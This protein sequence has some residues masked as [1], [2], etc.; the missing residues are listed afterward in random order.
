MKAAVLRIG[1]SRAALASFAGAVALCAGAAGAQGPVAPGGVQSLDRI[2]AVVGSRPILL[3]EAI[4]SVNAMRAQG[5]QMP[6]DSLGQYNLLLRVINDLVDNEVV[7]HVANNYKAA[8]TDEDVARQVDDQFNESRKR[9]AS[10]AEFRDA[11]RRDGFGTPEDYR[12]TIRESAKRYKLQQHGF[13]SLKAHGR[14]S[15]PVHVTEAEVN[16][17]FEASRERLP[18]RPATV[19]FRQ[20]VIAPRASPAAMAVARAKAESLV[21]LL[22]GGAD[23]ATVAKRE[24]MDPVSRE[25]GGDLGWAR[26]GSGFVPEFERAIF[27]LP[28]GQ[29]SNAVETSFGFHIIRVD[30]VQPAE[31]KSRHIL[32]APTLDSADVTRARLVADSVLQRWSGGASYDSLAARYHDPAEERSLLDGFPVDSLPETYRTAIEGVGLREFAK[33]FEIPDPR[34]NHPKIGI[35]QVLERREGGDYTVADWKERIRSQLTQEKQIRRALDQLRREQYVRI[36]FGE[37]V[38]AATGKVP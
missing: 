7:I 21:V 13:D 16:V 34:T 18:R 1:R 15:A 19:A 28:P 14:M 23:F 12:R 25:Q 35:I 17:A 20:I 31:V 26:R 5:Q 22:R 32:I 8:V 38:P 6:R 37:P 3:S 30:R 36:L 9:F 10:E 24:S 27:S 29:V 2:V 11:L 33:P 4:E